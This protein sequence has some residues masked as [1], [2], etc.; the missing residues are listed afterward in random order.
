[1]PEVRRKF[2]PQF[3]AEAVQLVLETKRPIADVAR[4]FG[5]NDGTLGNWVNKY[6]QEH[7]EPD[8]R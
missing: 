2:S 8:T 7:P 3:K 5:I 1:M 6:R 4:G